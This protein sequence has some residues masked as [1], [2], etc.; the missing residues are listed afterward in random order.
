VRTGGRLPGDRAEIVFNDVFLEYLE[1]LESLTVP[2]RESV[3]TDVV[4]LCPN[5]AGTRL[6]SNRSRNDQLAGWNTLEVLGREHR[7]VFGI[8]IENGVGV[9][10]LLCGGP[11]RGEAVHNMANLLIAAGRLTVEEVAQIWEALELLDVIVES[12]GLDGGDYRP[13]DAPPGMIRAAAGAGLLPPDI[14][15]ALS[16]DELEAA[17][18]GGWGDEGPG[19]AAALVAALRRARS[20]ADA[21]DVTRILAGRAADRCDAILPRAG[22][23]CT[24]R[25]GQPGP[26]RAKV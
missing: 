25:K 8:R 17:M 4:L 20:G 7:V 13:P 10:E 11:R 23:R 3:L 21:V 9:V 1:Y 19:M 24:R 5:P 18:E 12:V 15:A 14:A 16:H 22:V 26:H 6:L 2:Q